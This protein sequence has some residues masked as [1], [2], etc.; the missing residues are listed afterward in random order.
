ML[1]F[2]K[3]NAANGGIKNSAMTNDAESAIVL[4]NARGL[5]SY[6]V[7]YVLA[8]IQVAGTLC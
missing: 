6:L 3:R 1:V 2:L 7:R 4:V 8:C 5:N